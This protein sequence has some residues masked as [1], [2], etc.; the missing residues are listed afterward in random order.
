ML[1]LTSLGSSI[2]I[3]YKGDK[4]LFIIVTYKGYKELFIIVT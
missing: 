1:N 3:T 4:E 2:S